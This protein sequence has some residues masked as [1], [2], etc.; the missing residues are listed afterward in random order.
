MQLT[1]SLGVFAGLCFLAASS[2][3]VFKPGQWYRKLRKPRWNPPD[4]AFP[5]AWTLLFA[6]MAVAGWIVYET[7]GLAGMGLV[8]LVL[9]GVQLV[10]NALWSALFFGAKRMGWA[11]L[12]VAVL[13]LFIAATIVAFWPVAWFAAALMIPYL[14]WVSFAAFLNY[15]IMTLNPGRG[16][17]AAASVR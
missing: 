6:M 16:G 1:W 7:A 14:V 11:L 5:I 12:D 9:W 3:A 10:F 13:W 8:G 17:N 4:W 2:G 15:T